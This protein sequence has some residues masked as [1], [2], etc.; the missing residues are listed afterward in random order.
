MSK[1][2]EEAEKYETL[3]EDSETDS[4]PGNDAAA[5]VEDKSKGQVWNIFKNP[6]QTDTDTD[7]H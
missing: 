3:D 2:D 5:N 6:S 7:F 4:I 1:E